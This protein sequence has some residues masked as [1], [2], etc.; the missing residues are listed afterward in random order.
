[1]CVI[2]ILKGQY[3]RLLLT[4]DEQLRRSML[5]NRDYYLASIFK[6]LSVFD[7]YFPLRSDVM[8]LKT[9]NSLDWSAEWW[10]IA[11]FFDTSMDPLNHYQQN[12]WCLFYFFVFGNWKVLLS[13]RFHDQLRSMTH[14]FSSRIRI[15][16]TGRE[17]S[18]EWS[19]SPSPT[20]DRSIPTV[21]FS[22]SPR[23]LASAPQ[24]GRLPSSF[25]PRCG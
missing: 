13:D 11:V 16:S 17:S 8:L 4:C 1:M 25:P 9:I 14:P 10:S 20:K 5:A 22:S 3:F 12:T 18:L 21:W 7:R 15:P 24:I 6:S 19:P 2:K 23:S